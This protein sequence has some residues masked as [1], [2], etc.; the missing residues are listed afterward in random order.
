LRIPKDAIQLV[1]VR[2]LN[3]PR[4]GLNR[5]ANVVGDL[6]NLA[7]MGFARNLE[8]VVLWVRGEI[9]IAAGLGKRSLGF[10]I[11]DIAESL[12]KQERENELLIVARI[13]RAPQ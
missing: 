3:G 13:D 10:L 8:P 2:L 5:S 11:E 7:P 12:V 6:P 1:G 4:G 9:G